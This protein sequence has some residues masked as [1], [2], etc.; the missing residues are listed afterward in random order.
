MKLEV[1]GNKS[2]NLNTSYLLPESLLQI[3][4]NEIMKI[5]LCFKDLT[6]SILIPRRLSHLIVLNLVMA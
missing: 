3:S 6:S 2:S 1:K 4:S 5:L